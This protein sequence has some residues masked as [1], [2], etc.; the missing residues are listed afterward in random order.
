MSYLLSWYFLPSS[1]I[2]EITSVKKED[3]ISTLQYLNL[4]NYYK[5]RDPI[6]SFTSTSH[7]QCAFFQ[8]MKYFAV[9]VGTDGSSLQLKEIWEKNDKIQQKTWVFDLNIRCPASD[10]GFVHSIGSVHPDT[11]GG[12]SGRTRKGDAEETF[13]N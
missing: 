4:I 7:W 5:V 2:S 9:L 6:S 13:A 8:V 3:V 10:V 1:E 12:D 11:F